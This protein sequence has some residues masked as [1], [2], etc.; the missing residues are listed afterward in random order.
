MGSPQGSTSDWAA[1]VKKLLLQQ[2]SAQRLEGYF[3]IWD[4]HTARDSGNVNGIQDSPKFG[5][6]I[7]GIVNRGTVRG[8]LA[9]TER[10]P[11][12]EP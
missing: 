5:N 10:P 12:P 9:D 8:F 11:F 4:L 2:P 7:S 6:D 3:Q 1:L